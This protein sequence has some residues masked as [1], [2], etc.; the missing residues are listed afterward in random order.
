MKTILSVIIFLLAMSIPIVVSNIIASW[1]EI[2]PWSQRDTEWVSVDCSPIIEIDARD[3]DGAIII[4]GE[5]IPFYIFYN[6]ELVQIFVET[7]V[8]NMPKM[9][10]EFKCKYYAE[11]EFSA[12]VTQ[13]NIPYFE[14]GQKIIFR[15]V[16]QIDKSQ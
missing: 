3:I 6:H 4:D 11:D 7:S 5:K 13:S 10:L 8:E 16:D 14:V 2:W 12:K 9:I 1:V 15:R